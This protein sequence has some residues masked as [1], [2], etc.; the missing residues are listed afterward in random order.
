LIRSLQA[1]INRID[2]FGLNMFSDDELYAIHCATL[3][4]MRDTGLYVGS[5]E[6]RE[7]LAGVG[8]L[9]TINN[10]NFLFLKG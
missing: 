3:E 5:K 2:G 10:R 6:A 8:A 4:V 7:I 9:I 1:G